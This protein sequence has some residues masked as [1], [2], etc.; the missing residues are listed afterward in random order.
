ME[1]SRKNR[2]GDQ[3]EVMKRIQQIKT[4]NR[5]REGEERTQSNRRENKRKLIGKERRKQEQE[6]NKVRYN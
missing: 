4:E 6:K 5:R 3:M 1:E 2:K